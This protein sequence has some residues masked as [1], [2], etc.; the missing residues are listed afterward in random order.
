[1][2]AAL[3]LAARELRVRWRRVALAA[4]LVAALAAAATAIEILGRA[5]EEAVA[6]RIDEMGPALT[7]VPAGVTAGALARHELAGRLLPDDVRQR[8]G[9]VIGGDLRRTESRLVLSRAIAGAVTPVIGVENWR[10]GASSDAEGVLVGAELSRRLGESSSLSIDGEAFRNLGTR[11]SSGDIEDLAVTLPLARAG[12]L[13]GSAGAVNELRVYL[14][15][16]VSAPEVERRLAAAVIGAAIVRH[17]RGEVAGS[18]IQDSL[19]R[20][21]GLAYRVMALVAMICLLIVSHLDA[22]ERRLEISTL[23][24]IGA[25]RAS[26]VAALVG[27][28]MLLAAAGA[29]AGVGAG[30]ILAAIQDPAV[31]GALARHWSAGVTTIVTGVAVAALAAAPTGFAAALRDPV[32]ALQEG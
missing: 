10:A 30:F 20:H 1:M 28:S 17:D 23:V 32:P 31:A 25:P 6:A 7:I 11:P 15:A 9:A 5:R 27:R 21:R 4:A 18:E 29:T 12:S 22:A 26:I 13:A 19:A 24:A 14:R 16:G 3:W 2:T 8:V